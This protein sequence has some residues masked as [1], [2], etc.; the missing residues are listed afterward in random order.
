MDG[1]EDEAYHSGQYLQ[2]EQLDARDSEKLAVSARRSGPG[3]HSILGT[4][5]EESRQTSKVFGKE[6][7]NKSSGMQ[8]ANTELSSS[9]RRAK[10]TTTQ[11]VVLNADTPMTS[12]AKELAL[13]NLKSAR[14]P[15]QQASVD[16]PLSD[17]SSGNF[18]S[19]SDAGYSSMT[20]MPSF[21]KDKI[22]PSSDTVKKSPSTA[23]AATTTNTGVTTRITKGSESESMDIDVVGTP[24]EEQTHVLPKSPPATVAGPITDT[25][26]V[27]LPVTVTLVSSSQLPQEPLQA[28]RTEG[29]GTINLQK[30]VPIMQGAQELI[31]RPR[32]EHLSPS[33][34]KYRKSKSPSPSPGPSSLGTSPSHM[35]SDS[36]KSIPSVGENVEIMTD[37]GMGVSMDDEIINTSRPEG[38]TMKRM[39]SSGAETMAEFYGR[40]SKKAARLEDRNSITGKE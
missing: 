7:A 21:D 11:S 29:V 28:V 27:M 36:P 22:E 26:Q 39:A 13:F 31:E 4:K 12:V 30:P 16:S 3:P 10:G 32:R 2:A 6:E 20:S 1:Q 5:R 25:I 34:N 24:T 8:G 17:Y 33:P 38:A 18:P 19:I 9:R 35:R 40:S 23:A 37:S 14:T 15:H